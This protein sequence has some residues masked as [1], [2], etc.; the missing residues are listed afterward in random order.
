MGEVPGG[1]KTGSE[2]H[3]RADVFP[4]IKGTGTGVEERKG[5]RVFL[6]DQ[7]TERMDEIQLFSEF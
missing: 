5:R 4:T 1:R 6:K 7:Q 2:N 3:H